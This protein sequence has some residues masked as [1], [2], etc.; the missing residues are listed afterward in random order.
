MRVR[1]RGRILYGYFGDKI[2]IIHA[3]AI[4]PAEEEWPYIQRM[5]IHTLVDFFDPSWPRRV[6]NLASP[7]VNIRRVWR[8]PKRA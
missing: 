1:P 8:N 3:V 7:A 6:I 4:R 5:R 2:F